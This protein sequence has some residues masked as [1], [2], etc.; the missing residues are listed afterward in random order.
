MERILNRVRAEAARQAALIANSRMAIVTSYDPAQ[1][2]CKVLIMPEGA[3]Q[4]S[5]ES[6]ETG[7]LKVQTMW[8]G[9]GWGVFCPPSVGDQ[10]FVSH[11]EGDPGAGQIVGRVYDS[12][13]LALAVQSGEF[14][15]VHKLG[16]F[17][18]LTNDG[19]GNISFGGGLNVNAETYLTGSLDISEN[20]TVGNGASGAFTTSD[21]QTVTVQDGII[22]NIF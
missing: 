16:G 20:L 2:A 19:S 9:P 13:H 6:A 8:S 21:G 22:T 17:I 10:V 15:L 5:G 11:V 14:W 18:K 4:D 1:Y 3:F 7:W 12:T